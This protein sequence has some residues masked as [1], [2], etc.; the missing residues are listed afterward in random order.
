MGA[1]SPARKEDSNYLFVY[2]TLRRSYGN[3]P[4]EKRKLQPPHVLHTLGTWIGEGTLRGYDLW[5]LGNYP[6]IV[7]SN[8]AG[9]N[10]AGDV[11]RVDASADITVILDRYEGIAEE[12]MPPHEYRR[13]VRG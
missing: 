13:E 5:D 7:K 9:R 1:A 12:Y 4:L 11:F 6:G 2:G 10:V 3:L 8:L